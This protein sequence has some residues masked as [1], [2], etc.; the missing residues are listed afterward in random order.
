[1][2]ENV[3]NKLFQE[4]MKDW[5]CSIVERYETERHELDSLHELKNYVNDVEK[6]IKY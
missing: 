6:Q 2:C 3:T 1:M 4:Q 5:L